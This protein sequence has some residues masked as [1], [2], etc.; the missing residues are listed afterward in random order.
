MTTRR[1]PPILAALVAA[2]LALLPPVVLYAA[3]PAFVELSAQNNGA[4]SS[5]TIPSF[6]V[7]AGNHVVV[8]VYQS[9]ADSTATYTVT[10][11]MG[12]SYTIVGSQSI[13]SGNRIADWKYDL[14][15]PG[16]T[17]T[18]TVTQTGSTASFHCHALEFSGTGVSLDATENFQVSPA[19]ND[20]FGGDADG[21]DTAADAFIITG[22]GTSD[23]T[24]SWDPG[25]CG[26]GSYTE[27]TGASVSI[28]YFTCESAGALTDERGPFT[29]PVATRT[30]TNKIASFV[31]GGGGGGGGGANLLMMHCCGRHD[32]R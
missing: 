7:T 2:V 8:L 20:H 27:R 6:T 28:P 19:S 22:G 9:G 23:G 26:G 4:A 32:A 17:G 30:T 14:A 18:I 5:C 21:I 1:R 13:N 25:A 24:T 12:G 29:S 3:P 11:D 31:S 15:H 10:D 16:G